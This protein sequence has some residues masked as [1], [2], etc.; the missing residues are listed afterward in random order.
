MKIDTFKLELALAATGRTYKK[1]ASEAGVSAQTLTAINKG[2]PCRP[3][4]A[5]RLADALEI[6][7]EQL[8]E[9]KEA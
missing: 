1:L 9:T 8:L 3:N 4:I 2:K 7:L 6:L 5:G